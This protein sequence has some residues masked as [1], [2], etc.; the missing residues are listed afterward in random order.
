MKLWFNTLAEA[1]AEAERMTRTSHSGITY[2]PVF[3]EE[4]GKFKITSR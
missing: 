3:V 4:K 2:R 1:Q